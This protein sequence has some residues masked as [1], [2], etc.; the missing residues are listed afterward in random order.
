MDSHRP[1]CLKYLLIVVI[2]FCVAVPVRSRARIIKSSPAG[3]TIVHEL[4]L[5]VPPEEA[6]D[7]MTG[8]ISGWWDHS[9]SEEPAVL[10]IEAKPGG[11]FYELF[12]DSGD[13]VLH[14]T[15]TYAQ[16]GKLLR[17]EGPL[18]LAGNPFTLVMTFVFEPTKEG[19]SIGF[20]ASS[21]GMMEDGWDEAVDGVWYHFLFEQLKPWVEAG[22]HRQR[23]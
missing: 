8:D 9:F 1:N 23:D 4:V 3:F 14:A 15:V 11:R 20:T 5:P 10:F 19:T 2:A 7:A 6:Y 22:K 13:G 17:Y 18:G 12:D 21:M 16:R